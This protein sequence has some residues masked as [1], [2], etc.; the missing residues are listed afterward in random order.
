M[1]VNDLKILPIDVTF[2]F[3]MLKCWYL[4]NI[5]MTTWCIFY[6]PVSLMLEPRLSFQQMYFEKNWSEKNKIVKN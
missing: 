4:I 5:A 1:E 2:H 3:N 6:V